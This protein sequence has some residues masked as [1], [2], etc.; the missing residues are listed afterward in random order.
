MGRVEA[1]EESVQALDT[2]DTEEL[3]EFSAWPRQP[4]IAQDPDGHREF[5]NPVQQR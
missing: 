2:L 1:A 4:L 3:A 5:K